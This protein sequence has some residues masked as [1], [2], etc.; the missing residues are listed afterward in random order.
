MTAKRLF[1]IIFSFLGLLLLSPLFLVI[2]ILIKLESSGPIFFSHQR[3]GRNFK[4][5]KLYKFRTMVKDA[6]IKGPQITVGDDPRITRIGKFLRKT[7]LDEFPQLWNVLKGDMS[8]VGPRPEVEKYVNL[9]KKDYEEI[10]KLRPG[11]TDIASFI[12]SDEEEGLK[13]K[14]D[15]EEFYIHVLLP[16]KIKLAKEYTKKA[17]LEYDLKLILITILKLLYPQKLI[18]KTINM[19]TPYR[20]SAVIITQIIFLILSNYLAFYIRFDGNIPP[21]EI[22]LFFEYIPLLLGLRIIFLFI[23]SLDKGLWRYVSIK[24]LINIGSSISISTFFFFLVVRY[25]FGEKAYPRSIYAIDWFLSIF[26]LS[27]IRLFRRLNEEIG[28]RKPEKKRVI[29]IGAGSGAELLLRDVERSPNYPYEIIG[30]IDDDPNKKGLKIR[31]IPIL[32]TRKELDRIIEREEPDEFLIAIPSLSPTGL[33]NIVKD[34]RQYGLPIKKLPGLWNILYGREISKIENVEPEDVLFRPPVY[35]G[36]KDLREFLKHKKIMVTGAGGS[37]GSELLRQIA[38]FDPDSLILFEKHEESLYKID[39][40]LRS[41]PEAPKQI[42]PVI[43][44]ILDEYRVD[45]VMK[46]YKPQIIFHAAA[47][48]HVPLMEENPYEAFKTNV[49]GT[50]IIAE[51]A[52]VY[53]IERFILIS[54]DKAVNPVNVMGMTKKWAEELIRYFAYVSNFTKYITVRF[55]NVLESSGSV[56][57]LFKEQVKKGG[58]VTVTHP[59][60]TRYFMTIPEAVALVLE[61]AAIGEGGEIFVLDMGKPVKILD[62]AKRLISL[63]GY[64][65]G[66]DIEIVFTGLRPG[67]KLYE[68]LFNADEKIEKTSHPKI[69]KAIPQRNLDEY[70]LKKIEELNTPSIFQDTSTIKE[71]LKL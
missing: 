16:E 25:L 4:P 45:E 28:F 30:F 29:V 10:L 19:L 53:G 35:E 69:N 33:E 12:Y 34:L 65:P 1:D 17:S 32:G 50:K 60:I 66:I 54:T 13:N 14:K 68:E 55:G 63:Y 42:I 15:P 70:I 37:I 56:V 7:K 36:S 5:F 71:I 48:K 57:P 41:N 59:E 39:L 44:D 52:K 27:G 11:I 8:L 47:Y 20:K 51:R 58:P 24:D 31:G 64:R 46:K 23:F 38:S 9:Y 21:Q 62:L 43:G 22:Q 2:S 26:F 61:A 18:N 3:V 49:I 40:E 67:D 6:Q